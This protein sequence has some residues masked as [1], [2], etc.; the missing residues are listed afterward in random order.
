MY[1]DF[2]LKFTCEEGQETPMQMISGIELKKP[3]ALKKLEYE[4]G[5]KK[6][7]DSTTNDNYR[8]VHP[9][10]DEQVR[11]DFNRKIGITDSA[12]KKKLLQQQCE[13]GFDVPAEI[14]FHEVK[15]NV[16]LSVT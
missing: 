1:F 14:A 7:D 5:V 9:K 15:H 2:A 8:V 10:M 11:D 13:K 6:F 3:A 16:E 12:G 4:G